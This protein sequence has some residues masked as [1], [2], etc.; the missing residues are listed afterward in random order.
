M[1]LP[2]NQQEEDLRENHPSFDTPLLIIARESNFRKFCQFLVE[3]RYNV[4]TKDSLGQEL[5]ISQYKQG[6][7]FLGL[8]TYLDWIMILVTILS[9]VSM[10]FETPVNRVVDQPLL[11][12]AEY[13]F[14]IFMSVEL[15]LKIFAHGLVFTPK[16]L[17]RDIG[18]VIDVVVFFIGLIFLCWSPR[19][20]PANSLAQFLMLLRSI[21]PL[22]IFILVPDMK[23]V[24]YEVCRGFK[25]ILL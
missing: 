8:V 9:T 22:R 24:V 21:R 14:V 11:Q 17:I 19:K 10:S 25:E 23:K 18:G 12:I 6:H 5:K 2:I 3:A 7:K 15:T 1:I 4:K 20:V 16:A 13:A